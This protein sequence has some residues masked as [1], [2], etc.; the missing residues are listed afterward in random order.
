GNGDRGGQAHRARG[1]AGSHPG[2]LSGAPSAPARTDAQ[3]IASTG[4]RRAVVRERNAGSEGSVGTGD[5]RVACEFRLNPA[6]PFPNMPLSETFPARCG[7]WA[8]LET[9][10]ERSMA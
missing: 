6:G 4:P 1:S 8:A 2:F 10:R 7:A 9:I 5:E 3:R